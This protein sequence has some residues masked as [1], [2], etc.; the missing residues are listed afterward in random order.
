MGKEK[1]KALIDA[2]AGDNT[3]RFVLKGFNGKGTINDGLKWLLDLILGMNPQ[4]NILLDP[5]LF[6]RNSGS[7]NVA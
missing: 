6:Q 1:V 3:V 7:D 5:E 2:Y 4:P